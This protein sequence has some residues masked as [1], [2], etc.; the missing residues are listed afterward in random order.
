MK[1][2]WRPFTIAVLCLILA[3][4]LGACGSSGSKTKEGDKVLVPGTT[5]I[6]ALGQRPNWKTVE[7][8]YSCAPFVRVIG[9]AHAVGTITKATYQGYH[10]AMDI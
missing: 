7:E 2:R 4:A 10:A 8:L 9:D 3:L 1:R 5:I 6:C